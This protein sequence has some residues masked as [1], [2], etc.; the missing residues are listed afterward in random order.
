[1]MFELGARPHPP[2]ELYRAYLAQSQVFIGIYWQSYGWVAPGEQI[3]GLEDE[4]RLATGL[5]QLL[6]VKGPAPDR[7]P[8]LAEMLGRIRTEGGISYQHFTD[9]TELQRLVENDLA[10][11]LSE[12]FA[13]A[14]AGQTAAAADRA[15]AA[16]PARAGAHGLRP[17][18][19]S[20]TSLLG[21]EQDIDEVTRLIERP[22][23]RLVT[24]TGPGGVG[25]TRLAVALGERLRDRY[26]AGTV[27]VPLDTVTDPDSVLTAI[28]RAAGADLTGTR[29]PLEALA[30]TFGDGAWLLILDNLEQVV[31]VAR[32]LGELPA[33]CPRLAILATSR[34]V[35]RLRAE[36][37][38]PVRP[39][40]VPAHPVHVP[41][42]ELR[43]W[44]AV[45]LFADRARAVRPDFALTE[46]NAAAVAEICR[47]LEGLPL[48]IELA[49]ARTRLLEPAVLLDR[50]ARSLDALGTGAVD[51]PERQ[52]TLR[53]TVEWSV[54]LLTADERSLL[55]VTAVFVDGWTIQAVAQVAQV[56]EDLAL[57]LSEQLAGHSLIYSDSSQAGSRT[58]MLETVREFVTEQLAARA[59]AGQ[60]ERRHADYYRALAEQADRPLRSAGRGE[61]LERLDA[62]AG[63]LAAAVGWYLAQ[64]P[65]PLPHLFRILWLFWSLRDHERE[66]RSW[67]EQLLPTAGTLDLQPRVELVWAAA[68]TAVD[69]GND[70]AALTARQYLAPLL[71][72][73][74][75]PFLHAA[76]QLAMAWTLPIPGDFDGTLREAALALEEFRGQDEPI[77]T[78]MAGFTAGSVE[79][80]LGR[81][82]DARRHLSEARDL[83]DRAGD[84]LAAGARAQLGI[85]A[86]LQ[87]RLDEAPALLAGALE[88]SLAARSTQF[89]AMCLVG[90]AWLAFADGDL[91][92][93]ARLE[94]SAEGLRQRVGLPAWPHLR[95]KEAELVAQIRQRLGASQFDQ[96]FSAGSQL[97]QQQAV[98]VV[99]EQQRAEPPADLSR[100]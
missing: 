74:H 38:Y 34:T 24:L 39:L 43:S 90:Y 44:P 10:V 32:E 30:E 51:L 69:T 93:A 14:A 68:V 62:D 67:I 6:Y 95:K 7:E 73:I 91:D 80:A 81:Y 79:T 29:S 70:S 45:A 66:A 41:L 87:G 4:Y 92:R 11:L 48:A 2:R 57:E 60:I 85:L 88:V 21:R 37:E 27:Y 26:T 54:G 50:L 42:E 18:P 61:W 52:R 72:E 65:G 96:A 63:N 82:D 3:S 78:A 22:D 1:V 76:A 46:D 77:F 71:D 75:D 35:L 53:A 16:P 8:R 20:T 25:K 99:Q 89:V 36:Q 94:G 100:P 15:A 56:D 23:V 33:R 13:V 83:A 58:R 19:V 17:L 47:R 64:D 98:A 31:Q 5:P 49:A 84:W 59:D 9:A 28:S 12:R 86:V 40:P 97:T 55:E